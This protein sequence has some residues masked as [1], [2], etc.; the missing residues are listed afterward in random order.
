[1]GVV[2]GRFGA[3]NAPTA[4][5]AQ[6]IPPLHQEHGEWYG[7]QFHDGRAR[8]L[9]EQAAGPLLNPL[10][11]NQPD[12]MSVAD[13]VRRSAYADEFLA[14]YGAH[15]LDDDETAF[16]HVTEAIAAYERTRSFA[17]FSSKYDRY[18][19]G[20]AQLTPQEQRGLAVFMDPARGNCASCHPPPLF[21]NHGYANLGIP[22][23][24]NSKFA[25]AA[26]YVDHGLMATTGDP[27]D[28]GK[29][30]VPTL[31]NVM[32]T[33]PYGHN[34]YFENVP[35][36]L[37]FLATRD[38]KPWAPPEVA[39]NVDPRVGHLNLSAQD[40]E[41]LRVFLLTLDDAR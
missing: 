10:E 8:S 27:A 7:G 6:F 12:K 32:R 22:R 35:Y 23:Y 17:P 21:T 24:E 26:T 18:V 30:R 3:R 41:D 1:M 34:G 38:T 25:G 20:K 19:A 2:R 5:Y 4:M 9:E 14:V 31:R 33:G 13:A 40:L 16:R 36:M 37:E 15:A 11:M 39:A 28:D 29:F